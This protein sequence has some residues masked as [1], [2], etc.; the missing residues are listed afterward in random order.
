MAKKSGS[1][2]RTTSRDRTKKVRDQ[3]AHAR[4]MRKERSGVTRSRRSGRQHARFRDTFV[5]RATKGT[6]KGTA[7]AVVKYTPKAYGVAKTRVDKVRANQKFEEDYDPEEGEIPE[8]RFHLRATYS[9]CNRRFRTPEA[10]NAHHE[11]EHHGENPERSPRARPKLVVSNTKRSA[12]QRRV[13]PVDPVGGRHRQGAGRTPAE[14]FLNAYRDKFQE[15]GERAV[16]TDDTAT[17]MINKG[18]GELN[19]TA[20]KFSQMETT[21]AGLG[22]AF[23]TGEDAFKLYHRRLTNAGFKEEDVHHLLKMQEL[24]EELSVLASAHIAHLK[25]ELG[26]AIRAAK[27]R[28]AGQGIADEVLAN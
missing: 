21:A 18:F 22:Q 9:C 10:L 11:R 14:A 5:W 16:M 6:V 20:I 15:I 25:N 24:I 19:S 1:R 28:A 2:K 26:P 12:G 8:K 4:R 3:R 13:K 23:A 7:K 17:H 27:R